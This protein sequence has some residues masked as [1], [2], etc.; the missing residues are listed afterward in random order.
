MTGVP[1]TGTFSFN[2]ES[3]EFTGQAPPV[4]G[5]EEEKEE[6]KEKEEEQE[7]KQEKLPSED[8]I[9]LAALL[10]AGETNTLPQDP[11]AV[12]IT[13]VS[14]HPFN[15]IIIPNFWD[16]S[17]KHNR[18]LGNWGPGVWG[19]TCKLFFY[20]FIQFFLAAGYQSG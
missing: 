11:S 13:D 1:T 10:L 3:Q 9:Y 6:E 12:G 5:G 14:N 18:V 7:K 4:E 2:P 20:L 17:E 16:P 15:S 8:E 19:M